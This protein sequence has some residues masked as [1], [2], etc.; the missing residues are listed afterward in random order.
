MRRRI[1]CVP[2]IG[3]RHP[4]HT[5][6]LCCCMVL[7]MLVILAESRIEFIDER[8][9]RSCRSWTRP[10]GASSVL[11]R[12]NWA[13]LPTCRHCCYRTGLSLVERSGRRCTVGISGFKPSTEPGEQSVMPH[14][15]GTRPSWRTSHLKFAFW[16]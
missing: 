16:L 10:T 3:S 15:T 12:R 4:R 2:S 7:N 13:S 6:R 9:L 11:S 1:R 14:S 5:R 8:V